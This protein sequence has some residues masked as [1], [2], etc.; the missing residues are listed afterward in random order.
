MG[1]ADKKTMMWLHKWM[2]I[3]L[4][5]VACFTAMFYV[6]PLPV[7]AAAIKQTKIV[8]VGLFDAGKMM[9]GI[10]STG[11]KTG[12]AYEYLQEFSLHTGWRYEYVSGTFQEILAKLFTGEVDIVPMLSRTEERLD[13]IFYPEREFGMEYFFL[14]TI[15]DKSDRF[16]GDFDTALA[17]KRIGVDAGYAENKFLMAYLKEKNIQ[18]EVIPFDSTTKKVNALRKD[19]IDVLLTSNNAMDDDFVLLKNM[20]SMPCYIGISMKRPD[21]LDEMNRAQQEIYFKRPD[22][23]GYLIKKYFNNSPVNKYLTDEEKNLLAKH[24]VVR[25]GAY[26]DFYPYI[27][28]D[29]NGKAAGVFPDMVRLAIERLNLQVKQEWKFYNNR[30]ELMKALN[31][32][33][34]DAVVPE[35]HDLFDADIN[36]VMLS[37]SIRSL[38]MGALCKGTVDMKKMDVIAVK[39]HRL[40]GSYVRDNYSHAKVIDCSSFEECIDKLNSGEAGAAVA[41]LS[42]LQRYIRE[43]KNSAFTVMPLAAPC[44][45]C[46]AA[47]R[48]DSILIRLINR[49][50]QFIPHEEM[51]NLVMRYSIAQQKDVSP[52]E[53]FK[54]HI[55]YPLIFLLMV[56]SLIFAGYTMRKLKNS[57]MDLAV[58][59]M[60]I[61]STN[62]HLETLVKDRTEK[63]AEQA[64]QLKD[65]LQTAESASKAKTTF[66]FNMSHDIRTPM[67]AI[68][69]F[70]RMAEKHIGES[71]KLA[72]CLKKVSDA[73]NHLLRLINDILEMARI[74][75]G[76]LE[77]EEHVVNLKECRG[78]TTAM[79]DSLAK[80]KDIEFTK[81]YINVD[82]DL[83]LWLDTVRID[84]ILLNIISNSIKYTPRG[85]KVDYTLESLESDKIGHSKIRFTVVDN[86]IGMSKE[87]VEEIFEN[88]SRERNSTTSGIQ[89]TGLGMAIV[90]RLVDAMDGTIKVDSELGKGT[91]IVIEFEPRVAD[92]EHVNQVVQDALSEVDLTGLKVLLVEDNELNREIACE[93]LSEFGIEVFVAEDGTVAVDKM[94]KA[95][96]EQYDVILMDVQMPIMDGYK[97]TQEI[98]NLPDKEVAAIPIVAMTANAFAEDKKKAIESGM[99]DHLSKPIDIVGLKAVLSKYLK[100]D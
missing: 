91:T 62:E 95:V 50:L 79:V 52:V 82:K 92:N 64:E 20:G 5:V 3:V 84:Q 40:A 75:N 61:K 72:D 81:T 70:N 54:E 30:E 73:G 100:K 34:I 69:G 67:N 47:R 32:G 59:N 1:V 4:V 19:E 21:I 23:D 49:G 13:K 44:E 53:F 97:A 88:F 78:K 90:K 60:Q 35:Y 55:E 83:Y 51:D 8:K 57:Q 10:Q 41:P 68:L 25:L 48:N 29:E 42:I 56:G 58:A 37:D 38:S 76:K 89:G 12:Y 93:L 45:I 17:G 98:R 77:I 65:A 39:G 36:N 94:S 71:E 43:N 7:E 28:S 18:A 87:F 9:A 80:E 31:S 22:F 46:F 6:L 33:E 74:E 99:N 24:N 26:K 14:A 85:G 2:Q 86:G 11:H 15:P 63:L 96:P 27:F 66:L 16:S